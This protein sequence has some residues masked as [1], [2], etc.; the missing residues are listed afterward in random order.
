[1]ILPIRG[2]DAVA[3]LPAAPPQYVLSGGP[4]AFRPAEGSQPPCLQR[5]LCKRRT[6]YSV[7][8]KILPRAHC[9]RNVP[10][11]FLW[12]RQRIG[13]VLVMFGSCRINPSWFENVQRIG[14]FR[15]RIE[16]GFFTAARGRALGD[17]HTCRPMG[18]ISAETRKDAIG[19]TYVSRERH[20]DLGW[21]EACPW[22]P[23]RPRPAETVV[24][25]SQS[26]RGS[27]AFH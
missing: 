24:I 11:R 14:W 26:V 15:R 19:S 18:K 17:G 12:P 9:S 22:V 4:G 7:T 16:T 10:A 2:P 6:A 5:A 13:Y 27:Q 3:T 1:M 20:A 25:T 21:T 23:P 8:Q